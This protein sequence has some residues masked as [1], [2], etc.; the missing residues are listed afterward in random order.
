MRSPECS[1]RPGGGRRLRVTRSRVAASPGSPGVRPSGGGRSGGRSELTSPTLP[2]AARGILGQPEPWTRLPHPRR[3]ACEHGHSLRA[4]KRRAS[5]RPLHGRRARVREARTRPARSRGQERCTASV[6]A[7]GEPIPRST[8]G[9]PAAPR[10][11]AV[12]GSLS[13][14]PHPH[15][16]PMPSRR[17]PRRDEQAQVGSRGSRRVSAERL[18]GSNRC[19]ARD[20]RSRR[21]GE[22]GAVC[23][24]LRSSGRSPLPMPT[25]FGS[26]IALPF[27]PARTSVADAGLP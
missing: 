7:G 14:G 3:H 20:E 4:T 13:P 26:S 2:R 9:R 21:R 10:R 15:R 5:R 1:S 18:S 11:N 22:H 24:F 25:A 8:E 23:G 19:R 17:E 12:A 6:E 27:R 16:R